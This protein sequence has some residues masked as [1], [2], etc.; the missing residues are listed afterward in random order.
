LKGWFEKWSFDHA[1]ALFLNWEAID[2]ALKLSEAS[3]FI[4]DENSVAKI[5]DAGTK[6]TRQ[7]RLG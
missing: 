3:P 2:L 1:M 5:P 4:I 6:I 7:H